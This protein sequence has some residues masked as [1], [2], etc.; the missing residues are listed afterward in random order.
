MKKIS[1]VTFLI[2]T[3]IIIALF[4]ALLIYLNPPEQCDARCEEF[5]KT[6]I[7]GAPCRK[8]LK[9]KGIT[10]QEFVDDPKYMQEVLRNIFN[11]AIN[12]K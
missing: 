9:E 10:A 2:G 3:C 7:E 6:C 1:R 11:D 12:N 8:Y 4:I 5:K